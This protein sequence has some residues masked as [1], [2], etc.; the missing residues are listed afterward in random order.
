MSVKEVEE[1]LQASCAPVSLETPIGDEEHSCLGDLISDSSAQ[2]AEDAALRN[3][4]EN[5]IEKVLSCLP[6]RSAEVLRMRFGLAQYNAM[7]LEEVGQKL[8]IT[9]E[10]VRQI[11]SQSISR[12]RRSYKRQLSVG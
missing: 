5:Q 2:N 8:G 1:L 10:R 11:Q 3:D 9:R 7:T 4:M 6:E 12:L